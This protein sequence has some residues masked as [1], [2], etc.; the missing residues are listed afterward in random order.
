MAV[1]DQRPKMHLERNSAGAG[2][3]D[4]LA[5]GDAAVLPGELNDGTRV[6]S[7]SQASWPV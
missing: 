3:T 7:G 6:D 1:F 4:G 5:H 2:E